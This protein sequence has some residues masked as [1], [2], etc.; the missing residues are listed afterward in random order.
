MPPLSTWPICQIIVNSLSPFINAHVLNQSR[1]H[2]LL[3]NAF[4]FAISI[5]LKLKVK[6]ENALSFQTLM[7]KDY[8]MALELICFASNIRKEV[9]IMLN[10]FLS[11]LKKYE[12]K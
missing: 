8:S 11:L 7:E 10:S 2:W 12:E 4:N 6:H 3:S 1:G 9:C 5:S